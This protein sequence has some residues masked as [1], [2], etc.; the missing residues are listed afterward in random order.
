MVVQEM[1]Y[2]FQRLLETVDPRFITKDKPD[3]DVIL[4]NL[5]IAQTRF[6]F[7]KYLNKGTISDTLAYIRK[8]SDDLRNLIQ[9]SEPLNITPIT[10]LF[11]YQFCY[12]QW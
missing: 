6:I 12:R 8:K 10:T 4:L 11:L 9:P 1:Q 3:T 5:N 7:D 2:E